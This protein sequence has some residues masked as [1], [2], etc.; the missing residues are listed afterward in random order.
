MSRYT[1][2]ADRIGSR[3]RCEILPEQANLSSVVSEP[4]AVRP[5][6]LGK[7]IYA[8]LDFSR[9]PIYLRDPES[10]LRESSSDHLNHG[11][12][13][14]AN[15][16]VACL[17]SDS[18]QRRLRI[19]FLQYSCD[20]SPQN[21][22]VRVPSFQCPLN[23]TSDL[24]LQTRRFWFFRVTGRAQALYRG[25]DDFGQDPAANRGQHSQAGTGRT[26]DPS[27]RHD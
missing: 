24:R 13:I 18:Q 7:R 17:D 3:K 19:Y 22:G 5:S 26:H 16:F 21:L 15:P 2:R 20:S 23:L 14:M 4:A 12:H 25:E 8:L 11:C 10:Q 6:F 1:G 27:D 9:L